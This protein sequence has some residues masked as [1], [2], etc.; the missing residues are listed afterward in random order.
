MGIVP[1]S[2]KL[3]QYVTKEEY[4]GRVKLEGK[5]FRESFGDERFHHRQTQ[6]RR[7]PDGRRSFKANDANAYLSVDVLNDYRPAV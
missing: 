4:F 2:S 3:G 7:A 1:H 5:I 6:A